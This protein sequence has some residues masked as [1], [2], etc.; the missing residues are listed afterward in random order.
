MAGGQRK[1][2]DKIV[3]LK[4]GVIEAYKGGRKTINYM[5][6]DKCD[7]CYGTGG[8]KETCGTCNG[9][10]YFTQRVGNGFFQT[11][12]RSTCQ[13]CQGKGYKYT[14]ACYSCHGEQSM[15]KMQTIDVEL[16]SGID[17]GTFF[18]SHGGG[19]FINGNY[20]DLLFKVEIVPEKD[21]EKLGNSGDLYLKFNLQHSKL[22]K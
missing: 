14:K 3:D 8:D 20:S 16:P 7:V 1:N 10:G 5:R 15:I 17:D 9:Q 21:F 4:V 13:T 6:K 19:D 2:P 11:I 22:K 18:K 12:H